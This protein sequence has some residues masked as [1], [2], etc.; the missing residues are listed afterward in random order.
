MIKIF[1]TV[2]NRLAITTKCITAL[3]RHTKIPFE[4]Y[5]YD[6]LTNYRIHEHFMYWSILYEKKL[7]HQLTINTKTST[8]NSFS[9]AASCNQFGLWHEQDSNKYNYDFLLFLDNDMILNPGWDDTLIKS[10]NDVKSKNLKHILVITQLPGGIMKRQKFDHKIGGFDCQIGKLSGSGFWSVRPTFF[11]DVGFINLTRLTGLNKKH[12]QEYWN[13]MEIKNKGIP[14]ILGINS[15]MTFHCGGAISGSVCNVLSNND[16]KVALN[17]ITFE[18]SEKKIDNL[19]FDEFYNQINKNE[20][21]HK[22]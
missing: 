16:E 9:K 5:V 1:L 14:Y 7:I 13:L 19:S 12:D 2:R 4:L 18:E 8:F 15:K 17:K 21:L 11:K 10:W 3:Y 22:W 6:N 20:K